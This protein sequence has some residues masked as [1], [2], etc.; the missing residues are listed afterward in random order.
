MSMGMRFPVQGKPQRA[1]ATRSP[2]TLHRQ[3]EASAQMNTRIVRGR[4][5][6]GNNIWEGREFTDPQW[7]MKPGDK[8]KWLCSVIMHGTFLEFRDMRG[9]LSELLRI[10]PETDQIITSWNKY[11]FMKNL[12]PDAIAELAIKELTK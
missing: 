1:P 6:S 8:T 7:D 4:D 10:C 12:I 5:A 11:V 9:M 2:D 3:Q